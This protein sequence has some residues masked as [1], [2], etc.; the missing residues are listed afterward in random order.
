MSAI[1]P[2]PPTRWTVTYRETVQRTVDVHLT[3]DQVARIA[4]ASGDGKA[5]VL[6]E[7]A[8]IAAESRVVTVI[9]EHIDP[10]V[11]EA[12]P[13]REPEPPTPSAVAD[14]I[15]AVSAFIADKGWTQYENTGRGSVTLAQA[16]GMVLGARVEHSVDEHRDA[17]ARVNAVVT[18]LGHD[19]LDRWMYAGDRSV[20]VLRRV[21]ERKARI[22]Q[23]TYK[24]YMADLVDR[25]AQ[26][27]GR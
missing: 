4:A 14:D 5:A 23:G 22:A 20:D 9:E 26:E 2:A 7:A 6:L 8:T 10:Q 19:F 16:I 1:I 11:W 25:A 18:A 21:L 13:I 17:L 24:P 27:S 3:T 12:H 15:R